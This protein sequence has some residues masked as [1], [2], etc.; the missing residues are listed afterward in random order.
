[1]IKT[2]ATHVIGPSSVVSIDIWGGENTL[3]CESVAYIVK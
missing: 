3:L 1:M 2:Y